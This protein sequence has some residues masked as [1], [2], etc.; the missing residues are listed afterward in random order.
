M[1]TWAL[2]KHYCPSCNGLWSCY[3]D[4]IE[5]GR[6]SALQLFHTRA[7]M[8]TNTHTPLCSH[9]EIIEV[10]TELY[11][12]LDFL[13][14]IEPRLVPR[15]PSSDS[16]C[17]SPTIFNAEA[18]SAAGFSAEAVTVLSA[19]PY[20]DVGEHEM[21]TELQPSTYPSSYLGSDLSKDDFLSRREMLGDDLM[22]PSAIQLTWEEGGYGI[23]YIYDTD[24]ST[25]SQK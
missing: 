23:V 1:L 22:P 5:E 7:N 6:P 17:H 4:D 16:F 19:L 25:D 14:A 2:K 21:H 24:T 10:L 3:A 20:L 15:F 18:A 13:A 11:T 8:T 12:L 9:R